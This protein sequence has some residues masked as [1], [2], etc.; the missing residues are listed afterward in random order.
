MHRCSWR[1]AT[2]WRGGFFG[3]ARRGAKIIKIWVARE[4]GDWRR[5]ALADP[6]SGDTAGRASSATTSIRQRREEFWFV[7]AF[8]L[9]TGITLVL[10]APTLCSCCYPKC[11]QAKKSKR[12]KRIA[13]GKSIMEQPNWLAAVPIIVVYFSIKKV[14]L[15]PA[16]YGTTQITTATTVRASTAAQEQ[17]PN[18]E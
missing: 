18:Q 11:L 16:R 2:R 17:P 4:C 5:V 12:N 9:M 14:L 3:A 10:C 1:G 8:S 15:Q 6:A 7:V 13:I